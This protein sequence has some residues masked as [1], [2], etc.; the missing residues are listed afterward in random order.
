MNGISLL[1]S[2]I[3]EELIEQQGL[4][5]QITR[6]CDDAADEVHFLWRARTPL[7]PAWHQGEFHLFQ[8]GNKDR[9]N[10]LPLSECIA[11]ESLEEGAWNHCQKV[12]ILANYGFDNHVWYHIVGGFQGILIHDTNGNAHLYLLTQPASHYYE[13]MTRSKRMPIFIGQGI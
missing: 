11:V 8:W 5:N 12:E 3:P 10:K 13:V 4:R 7:L 9:R 2:D 1:R 6:R